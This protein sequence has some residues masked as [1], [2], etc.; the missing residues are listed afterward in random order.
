MNSAFKN[1]TSFIDEKSTSAIHKPGN[2]SC[3]SSQYRNALVQ[4]L[5]FYNHAYVFVCIVRGD[6]LFSALACV[7]FCA[8]KQPEAAL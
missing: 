3:T 5:Y 8:A 7:C 6:N 1:E 4:Q 2:V